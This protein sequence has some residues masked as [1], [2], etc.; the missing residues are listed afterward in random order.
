VSTQEIFQVFLL[1]YRD[2]VASGIVNNRMTLRRWMDRKDDPF[3]QAIQ[4]SENSIAWRAADVENW[5]A[6]RAAA[7]KNAAHIAKRASGE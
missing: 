5:I 1:R 3:P 4:L 6:R 7:G 2:L